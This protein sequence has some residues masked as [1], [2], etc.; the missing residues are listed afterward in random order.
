MFLSKVDLAPRWAQE[1]YQWHRALWQLFPRRPD[2][3]RDFLFRTEPETSGGHLQVLLQSAVAPVDGSDGVSLR[4]TKP[5]TPTLRQGQRLRFHLV[6][7]PVKTIRDAQ[8]RKNARGEIKPCR[9]PLI[10]G[11]QQEQWLR[12]KLDGAAELQTVE[13]AN[14]PAIYFHR[15]GNAGKVV[16]VRFDGILDVK[17]PER[18]LELMR[19]GIGPAKSFGCGLLSLARI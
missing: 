13:I 12:R 15:Q 11:D 16:P 9:V 14:R 10:R 6:A 17:N 1:P 2:A 19:I 8:E 5:F 18:L 7:N 4:A 3:V